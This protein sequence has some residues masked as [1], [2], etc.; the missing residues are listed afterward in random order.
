MLVEVLDFL[1]L[2]LAIV[3][4]FVNGAQIDHGQHMKLLNL[5]LHI[6]LVQ[7]VGLLFVSVDPFSKPIQID[8]VKVLDCLH[9]L[10]HLDLLSDNLRLL[11][12]ARVEN[13]RFVPNGSRDCISFLLRAMFFIRVL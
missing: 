13:A 6:F 5:G 12:T 9:A 11:E 1:K 4:Y 7:D 2:T 8:K 3:Q 10:D